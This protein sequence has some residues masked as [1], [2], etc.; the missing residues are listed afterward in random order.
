[1]RIEWKRVALVASCT[2]FFAALAL[3]L[4]VPLAALS[5]LAAVDRSLVS[6]FLTHIPETT[7]EQAA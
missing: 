2:A 1:M 6:L 3:D 4:T 5:A 7:G